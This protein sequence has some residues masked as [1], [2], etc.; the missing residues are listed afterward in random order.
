M[1]VTFNLSDGAKDIAVVGRI[2]DVVGVFG[3]TEELQCWQAATAPNPG[4]INTRQLDLYREW[5]DRATGTTTIEAQI[6]ALATG[7]TSGEDIAAKVVAD[8]V[9]RL[10]T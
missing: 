6:A 1:A 7:D 2:G 8:L 5:R 9:G 3:S 4:V 10:T